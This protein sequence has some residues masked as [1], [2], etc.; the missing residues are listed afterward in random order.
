MRHINASLEDYPDY[1]IRSC[2]NTGVWIVEQTD[3][4]EG[5]VIARYDFVNKEYTGPDTGGSA[6]RIE[7]LGGGQERS[8]LALQKSMNK[9]LL[10]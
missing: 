7:A 3:T 5:F 2:T 8:F 4:K 9:A 10:K 1:I 6:I